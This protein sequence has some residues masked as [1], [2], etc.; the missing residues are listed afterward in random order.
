MT[1]E[2]G[3]ADQVLGAGDGVR[4]E[5]PLVKTYGGQVAADHPAGGGDGAGVGRRRGAGERL[6]AWR[7]KGVVELRRR[8]RRRARR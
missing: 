4:T 2:P 7:R 3:A 6:D 8:R 5:F 1:G